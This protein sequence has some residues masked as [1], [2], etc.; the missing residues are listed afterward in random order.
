MARYQ[1]IL[2]YDGTEYFGFQR[3][4]EDRTQKTVQSVVET[5]LKRIGWQDG[6]I[7]AAGRTDT[8][9]HAKG[10]V[11][12][13]DLDWRHTPHDLMA[14]M[15]ANLPSDVAT[16]CVNLVHNSFHPRF[17]AISRTYQYRIICQPTRDP[18]RER[19]AWRV[20]PVLEFEVLQQCAEHLIGFHDFAAF[21]TPPRTGGATIRQVFHSHWLYLNDELVFEIQANAFL[22]HMVRRLVG[23]QVSIGQGR[24]SLQDLASR[25]LSGH[26]DLVK[27]LAPPQGL[28]L[29]EVEY[30]EH[31]VD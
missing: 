20:F 19:Y 10:Q 14:A 9:V 4:A 1:V 25:L 23:F 21:G 16:S 13:F 7:L 27:E 11:I 8:G 6:S 17:D 29:I 15:N 24:H 18:L 31:V 5:A 30:P 28:S 2:K 26:H 12:A 22:Y 3:Q